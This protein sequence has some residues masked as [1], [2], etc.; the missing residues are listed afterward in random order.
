[1]FSRNG[2]F[3]LEEL[4]LGLWRGEGRTPRWGGCL[5]ASLLSPRGAGREGCQSPA[6]SAHLLCA[7]HPGRKESDQPLP[8]LHDAPIQQLERHVAREEC[9]AGSLDA[10]CNGGRRGR[11][12]GSSSREWGRLWGGNSCC[13]AVSPGAESCRISANASPQVTCASPVPG[14]VLVLR[15]AWPMHE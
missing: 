4:C 13:T 5:L 14:H 8:G 11:E 7:R 2:T 9:G 1:M 12:G 6:V 10:G 15:K 3:L